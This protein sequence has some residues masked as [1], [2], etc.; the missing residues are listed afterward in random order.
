MSPL[1]VQLVASGI[2]FGL[3]ALLAADKWVHKVTGATPIEGRVK[4]LEITLTRANIRFSDK[5]SELTTYLEA[6]RQ[7]HETLARDVASLRG[8][9]RG[10]TETPDD[11]RGKSR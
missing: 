11:R 10:R 5:M 8:E 4:D 7:E 9:F 3:V 1:A 2:Q 6:R